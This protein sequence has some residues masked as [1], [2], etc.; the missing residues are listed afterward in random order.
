VPSGEIG[1][2]VADDPPE[3]LKRLNDALS[4]SSEMND[5]G[6]EGDLARPLPF[7]F[8]PP[9]LAA[10]LVLTRVL[11]GLRASPEPEAVIDGVPVMIVVGGEGTIFL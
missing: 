1:E 6:E 5:L 2:L 7:F 9:G 3:K 8:S 10:A 11:A 4:D